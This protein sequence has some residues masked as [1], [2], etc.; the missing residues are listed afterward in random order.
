MTDSIDNSALFCLFHNDH[1]YE[2]DQKEPCS[3]I[4]SA[5]VNVGKNGKLRM[6]GQDYDGSARTIETDIADK[7]FNMAAIVPIT[8][9]SAQIIEDV[10]H[11]MN[12]LSG[13]DK[14]PFYFSR[15][16]SIRPERERNGVHAI[17]P[18]GH[19]DPPIH[20]QNI[21]T[22]K[23]HKEDRL[24]ARI[25]CVRMSLLTAQIAGIDVEK[26]G[27][28]HPAVRTGEEVRDA[29][30]AVRDR[31]FPHKRN[32]D[33]VVLADSFS[34]KSK[35]NDKQNSEFILAQDGICVVKSEGYLRAGKILKSLERR[36][37][38]QSIFN[39]IAGADSSR[40]FIKSPMPMP[41]YLKTALALD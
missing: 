10:V 23:T 12:T 37:Q 7:Q 26:I 22:Y 5:V 14:W 15:D 24:L 20:L 4:F 34:D 11:K 25:N 29:I 13:Q 39:W 18:E 31:L 41:H 16:L 28:I 21:S 38:G 1:R 35:G 32:S 30:A 6:V 3:H 9:D 8:A 17:V 2:T 33:V 19:I 36:V 27:Q 40:Q